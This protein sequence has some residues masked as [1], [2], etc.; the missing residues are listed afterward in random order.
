M[1]KSSPVQCVVIP[2][3][4]QKGT[5]LNISHNTFYTTYVRLH[6]GVQIVYYYIFFFIVTS[7]DL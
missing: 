7:S 5:T 2:Q 3:M 1:G 4:I 6:V